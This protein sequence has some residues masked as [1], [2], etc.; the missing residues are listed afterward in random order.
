MH[1]IGDSPYIIDN[2][3]ADSAP[4]M[5]AS[6]IYTQP[7]Q[8]QSG[9]NSSASPMAWQLQT[10]LIAATILIGAITVACATVYYH[11]TRR[12]AKDNLTN[13][14]SLPRSSFGKAKI[15]LA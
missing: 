9:S 15:P 2:A 14:I 5:T 1:G 13:L 8:P 10:T 12:L 7:D 6:E 11:K 3:T 4:L